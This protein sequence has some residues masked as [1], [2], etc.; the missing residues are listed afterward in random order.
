MVKFTIEQ[1]R[2]WATKSWFWRQGIMVGEPKYVLSPGVL[3]TDY[4]DGTPWGDSLDQEN[5]DL[6]VAGPDLAREVIRLTEENKDLKKKI[7]DLLT[8][9]N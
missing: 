2:I 8:N 3:L 9:P 4:K 7:N 6:I 5:A 1:I